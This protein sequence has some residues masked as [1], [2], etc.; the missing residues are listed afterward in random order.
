MSSQELLIEFNNDL[1]L[2]KCVIA[3]EEMTDMTSQLRLN[4]LDEGCFR[5]FHIYSALWVL[6]ISLND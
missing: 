5:R 4:F 6:T 1:V 3:V 2:L